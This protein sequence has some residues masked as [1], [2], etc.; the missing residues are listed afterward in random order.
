M[1]VLHE[2]TVLLVM[3]L[4]SEFH[5][6]ISV[7]QEITVLLVI[8]LCDDSSSSIPSQSLPPV[9]E[10]MTLLVIMFLFE[11]DSSISEFQQFLIVDPLIT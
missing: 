2:F 3:L 4:Y 1:P 7:P 6:S 9:I 8:I 10:C 11:D 5:S